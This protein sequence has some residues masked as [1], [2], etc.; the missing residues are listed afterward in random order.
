M[1]GLV[2]F[3]YRGIEMIQPGKSFLK[4]DSWSIKA[5]KKQTLKMISLVESFI[6]PYKKGTPEEG[7]RIQQPKR[8][9]ST[10]NNKDEDTGLFKNSDR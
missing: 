3:V 6:Y 9:V 10:S 5:I 1:V 4:F 8:R 2:S 7:R